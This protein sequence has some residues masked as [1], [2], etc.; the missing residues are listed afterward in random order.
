[1]S[2]KRTVMPKP[3][4]I[5][6]QKAEPK[7]SPCEDM[8]SN[9]TAPASGMS[10]KVDEVVAETNRLSIEKAKDAAAEPENKPA[11]IKESK[12]KLAP[13]ASDENKDVPAEAKAAE[14]NAEVKPQEQSSD[15]KKR[16]H[17]EISNNEA[18]TKEQPKASEEAEKQSKRLKVDDVKPV[19]AATEPE[20]D[21][22]AAAT[23]EPKRADESREEPTV[24]KPA[25][26]Q[27]TESK[28]KPADE[29]LPQAEVQNPEPVAEEPKSTAA[30]EKPASPSVMKDIPASKVQE[31]A[32]AT[33]TSEPVPQA[34]AATAEDPKVSSTTELE[35]AYI[36]DVNKES[37]KAPADPA[38]EAK[39][40]P[41]KET[42]EK[43]D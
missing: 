17:E 19:A 18:E 32:F 29:K 4:K 3:D 37:S 27:I 23:E 26:A 39:P 6:D 42:A 20:K 40:E 1:M 22:V 16:A 11:E 43:K 30:Q 36:A 2:S 24:E 8:V 41:S 25:E 21:V 34:A 7:T 31:N 9:Q 28:A 14:T 33:A 10:A 13:Q 5:L 38:P 35:K 12:S 15:S